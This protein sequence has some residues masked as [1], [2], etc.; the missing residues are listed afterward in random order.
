MPTSS[1]WVLTSAPPELPGFTAASVWMNDSILKSLGMAP[2]CRAL[3]LTMPAVMVDCKSNGEPIAS[4]HSPRRSASDDPKA[5][6]GS[7]LASTFSSAR[8]VAESLP[9]SLA[10]N[11]RPS[12]SFTLSFEAPST[13][14]LFVTI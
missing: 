9:M 8:S 13:T 6:V 7:P 10:S 14:W 4:T 2:S 12:L 11:E 1:P 5:S 3:A